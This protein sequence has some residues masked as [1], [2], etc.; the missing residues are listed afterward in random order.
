MQV[1]IAPRVCLGLSVYRVSSQGFHVKYHTQ[2]EVLLK[3]EGRDASSG[4]LLQV[5]WGLGKVF[6]VSPLEHS[7]LGGCCILWACG[8]NWDER[9]RKTQSDLT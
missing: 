6:P 2:V 5:L 4:N 7:G 1:P 3:V 9:L 8:G